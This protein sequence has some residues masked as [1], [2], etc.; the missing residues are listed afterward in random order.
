MKLLFLTPQ[1]PYPPRQGAA[2]RN[3]HLLSRL[4]ARHEVALLTFGSHMDVP[5]ALAAACRT[6]EVVPLPPRRRRDR[7]RT[8]VATRLPDLARRLWSPTFSSRLHEM[9]QQEHYDWVQVEGLEMAPYAHEVLASGPRRARPRWLLDEHNAEYLLQQRAF[10]TDAQQ[11]ATWPAAAYS[12]VQYDRLRRY[13]RA[14]CR[15]A[16]QVVAESEADRQALQAVDPQLAVAVVPNGVDLYEWRVGAAG[17]DADAARLSA[18]GPLVVFDGSMDFRPNVD[19]VVW[20]VHEVWP[21]VRREVPLAQFAIVGRN[22]TRRV[23]ALQGERGVVVTGTVPDTRPWVA[24]AA[25][26]VVPMRIGGG[27]RLKVLQALAMER[28]LVSTT[29]GCEGVTVTDGVNVRLADDPALFARGVIDLLQNES[30][31][32]AL[33]RAARR[34]AADYA[35]EQIAPRLEALLLDPPA[36]APRPTR[37][38]DPSPVQH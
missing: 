36:P 22:P 33:G 11:P 31:R 27:V 10:Q 29:L 30:Q 34:L 38:A 13:E 28:A 21:L 6:V 18:V 25:V 37:T 23:Q 5:D 24:A 14:A 15:A 4:A 9:L 7:L 19:A 16:D 3:W 32:Q 2:I 26:Y 35:W 17:H 12:L 1:M 20:F 8:L